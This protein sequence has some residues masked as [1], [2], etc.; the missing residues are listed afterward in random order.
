MENL[1]MSQIEAAR[2]DDAALT[3]LISQK[4]PMIN[5]LASAA[6]CPGLDFD[7]AVQEGLIGFFSAVA[8]YNQDKGA[9]FNTYANACVQNAMVSAIRAAQRRKHQPLNSFVPLMDES[10]AADGP[11][12]LAIANEDYSETMQNIN[13]KL[14]PLEKQV[15][16]LHLGGNTYAQ[17]SKTL[18]IPQKS[19]DNALARIRR[20]LR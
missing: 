3:M 17:I 18:A 7:D 16:S 5:R 2:T 10:F 8:T 1:H 6:V 14:S 13:A 4:M 20:K 11:E 15:L 12:Q 9:S 19:V